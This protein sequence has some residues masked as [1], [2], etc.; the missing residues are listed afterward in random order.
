MVT[1]T[2]HETNAYISWF[3]ILICDGTYG[4]GDMNLHGTEDRWIQQ[5]IPEPAAV[6]SKRS[7]EQVLVI[8]IHVQNFTLSSSVCY[9][10]IRHKTR[11]SAFYLFS[12]FLSVFVCFA[13]HCPFYLSIGLIF[14]IFWGYVFLQII[15]SKV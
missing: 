15:Y 5:I 8:C 14:L 12:C 7:G 3:G 2:I 1:V 9:V 10:W 11:K 4:I 6:P 13:K